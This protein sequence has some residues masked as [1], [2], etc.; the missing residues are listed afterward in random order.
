MEAE[1]LRAEL[2]ETRDTLDRF[3]RS[4]TELQKQVNDQEEQQILASNAIERSPDCRH[5]A[6]CPPPR[7]GLAGAVPRRSRGE[8][9]AGAAEAPPNWLIRGPCQGSSCVC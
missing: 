3:A 1:Q 4:N 7:L 5:H 9:R 8:W 6:D 2:A